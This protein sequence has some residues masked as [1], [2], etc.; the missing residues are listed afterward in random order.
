MEGWISVHRKIWEHWL[1]EKSRPLT[2]LEAWLKIL[3]E[4]N[5]EQKKVS[6]GNELIIVKRGESINSLDTWARLFNW[7]KSKVRRFFKLLESDSMIVLKSNRKTTHLNVCNYED[8]QDKRNSN[9]T[10]MKRKRNANETQMTPNNN[11]NNYN[12]ENKYKKYLLSEIEISE[13]PGLNNEYFEIAKSFR[14]LFKKNLIE[15][16][17]STKTV[18]KAKGTWVDDVRLM[19]ENDGYSKQDLRDVWFFLRDERPDRNGFSWGAN[20]LSTSKLRQQMSKL[21]LK[22]HN[23]A[24]RSSNKEATS[25]NELAEVVKKSFEE[26]E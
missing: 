19:I 18:D 5:H 17:A 13:H 12:N 7:D 3:M 22:I 1:V 4:V 8:Y 11:V 25:W 21:K 9:E 24:N 14:D 15:A 16:G 26:A 10:Q 23:G 20:I 6:L 2:R